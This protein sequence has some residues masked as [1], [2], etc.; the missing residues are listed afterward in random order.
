MK[1]LIRFILLVALAFGLYVGGVLLWGTLTDYQPADL[2]KLEAQGEAVGMPDSTFTF[3]TWNIGFT[4]LGEETDFF[5]D[6]GS[7]VIQTETI[8]QKNLRGITDFLAAQKD[9]D[10]F[11]LQE[12]DSLAR[13]SHYANHLD[14]FATALPQTEWSFGVNYRV[15]FVPV[16]IFEPM[17]QVVSGIANFSRLPSRDHERHAYHSQFDWPTRIFFLDRCFLSQRIPLS[18][19]KE[20]IAINTHCSAYDT[21]GTMVADEIK[22]LMAFAQKEYEKGNY[23]VVGGDWNQ[24][25]PNYTPKNTDPRAYNEYILSDD[26]LP[27]GWRWVADPTIPTNRKLETVYT[28]D[29]YTS[30]IDHFVVSPNLEVLAV[31]GIDLQFKYA[32]HQPVKLKVKLSD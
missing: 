21:A 12:V 31:E 27:D 9:V 14:T 3:L 23:V 28:P 22:L 18:N 1:K 29:S 30:V 7:T 19:G 13:R 24:C 32:D 2:I 20:L 26:Q 11:F 10:V 4:G 17:G 25:P 15:D 6:G 16:P 5:Y 8:V